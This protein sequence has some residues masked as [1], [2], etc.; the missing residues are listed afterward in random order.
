MNNIIKSALYKLLRDWTFRITLIVGV[1]LA[2]GMN[3]VYVGIDAFAGEVLGQTCN[4]Q[5][6]FITSLSP[7][8][9]FGLAVPINLIVFTIGEFNCGTIRNKII[10]GNKRS[11]IYLSLFLIGLIFTFSLLIVYFGISV[12]LASIIGGFD[13]NGTT[14]LLGYLFNKDWLWQ[15]PLMAIST[16]IFICSFTVFISCLTRNIGGAMPIVIITVV[17]L[18]F[19]PTITVLKNLFDYEQGAAI[20]LGI[21][22]W[23]NPF[24]TFGLFGAQI[25]NPNLVENWFV[26]SIVTPLY[27]SALF[28]FLGILLFKKIDVK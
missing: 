16:Y 17:F 2:I 7:T 28:V 24:T 26:P 5:S 6:F 4:G 15:F 1:A 10:A 14:G 20:D 11:S 12:G 9:N 18:Y 13:P 25:V 8:Q 27:W 22:G 23:L 3:L 21:Q 19:L